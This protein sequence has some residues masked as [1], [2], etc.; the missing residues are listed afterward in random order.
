LRLIPRARRGA[1]PA[2]RITATS[3][4][5]ALAVTVLPGLGMSLPRGP[6]NSGSVRTVTV[7]LES[8]TLSGPARLSGD[9]ITASAGHR[10]AVWHSAP[11][12]VDGARMVGLS[13]HDPPTNRPDAEVSIRTEQDGWNS[14]QPVETD[15]G[16]PDPGTPDDQRPDR[17]FSQGTWLEEGT[18]AVQVQ[19]QL[20]ASARVPPAPFG[21]LTAHLITPDMTPT[22]SVE[23]PAGAAVARPDAP[24]IISRARWGADER[25]RRGQP[26][27]VRHL[28]V[29][30]LHHTVQSNRY[31]PAESAALVRADYLYHVRSRGYADIGYNF[32]V[33]RYGN[34]F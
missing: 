27:Y 13:W 1:G 26:Q 33:D 24:A 10:S 18:R 6:A 7:P 11:L 29:G 3:V 9:R 16:T 34:I 20:P 17:I 8:G 31:S 15:V 12:T 2:V 21:G 25:L 19:V 30:F 5:V 28:Q 4:S 32:L 23:P 22:P 14:W